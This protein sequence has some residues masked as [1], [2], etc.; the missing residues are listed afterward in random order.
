MLLDKETIFAN[1]NE[2]VKYAV[3]YWEDYKEESV[4]ADGRILHHSELKTQSGYNINFHTNKED[5]LKDLDILPKI[6]NKKY[7]NVALHI[8]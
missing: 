6:S 8:R 5:A 1:Q 4:T 7:Y 2:S 3:V